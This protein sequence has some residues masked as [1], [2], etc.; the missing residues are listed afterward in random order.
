MPK[1]MNTVKVAEVESIFIA[2]RAGIPAGTGPLEGNAA[3]EFL[4]SSEDVPFRTETLSPPV[5]AQP[6][7]HPPDLLRRN[8]QSPGD[9]CDL[10]A[11]MLPNLR[12]Y[13]VGEILRQLLKTSLTHHALRPRVQRRIEVAA[14]HHLRLQHLQIFPNVILHLVLEQ[15][16]SL[17]AQIACGIHTSRRSGAD[18]QPLPDQGTR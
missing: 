2:P 17:F 4:R 15:R 18:R 10:A 1:P 6:R 3:T 9:P 8:R 16:S 5:E 7:Q 14:A 11:L 13:Q 12:D